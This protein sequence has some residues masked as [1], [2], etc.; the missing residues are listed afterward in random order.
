MIEKVKKILINDILDLEE[1]KISLKW[2]LKMIIRL[3]LIVFGIWL[4]AM[5]IPPLVYKLI[6]D[7]GNGFG[8]MAGTLF[9]L[10]GVFANPLLRL[11][12]KLWATGKGKAFL[13]VI[14]AAAIAFVAVFIP[15]LISVIHYSE[16]SAADE[17]TVIVLGCKV[18]GTKPSGALRN[19]TNAAIEY[20][21]EHPDA[22]AIL[23][24][25]Q[26]WDEGIS[27]AECMKGIMEDAGIDE[28]RYFIEDKSTST[29]E[30][31]AFSK[32]IIEENGLS[33]N[34]AVATHD[35]HQ[36][37]AAMIAKKNGYEPA[38]LPV[39]SVRWSRA[40]FFTREVFG[41]WIQWLKGVRS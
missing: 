20:L 12:A 13:I 8:L 23:S 25:G 15:T 3:A 7:A 11:A 29:D 16:Y 14:C 19:R 24:G 2:V 40:T 33:M 34:V 18:N 1:R 26:G 5:Y 27:E 32:K 9:V 39:H 17:T 30:N 21:N 6:L 31:F 22:V 41:I 38:S 35:Y 10:A 37:R 36:K 28:S 4:I